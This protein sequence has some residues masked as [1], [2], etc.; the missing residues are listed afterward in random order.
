MLTE[1]QTEYIQFA[2]YYENNFAGECFIDLPNMLCGFLVSVL[3]AYDS[4]AVVR[5]NIGM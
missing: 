3:L 5:G 2:K 4:C 1:N